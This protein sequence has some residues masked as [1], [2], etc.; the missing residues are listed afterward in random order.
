MR[1]LVLHSRYLS[2]PA[3]GENRVVDDEIRLLNEGGHDVTSWTP[4]LDDDHGWRRAKAGVDVVWSLPAARTVRDLMRRHRPDIVHCHNVFPA[5][6][7]AVLRVAARDARVVVTLHNYR[8][9]C[10]PATFLRDNRTCEDCLHR[11]VAWPGVVHRCYRNSLAA[12]SAVALSCGLHRKMGT[13]NRVHR[14][15]AV[16]E[17][18]RHKHEQAGFGGGRMDVKPNFAWPAERRSGPGDYFL[19]MGRLSNE[20]GL[21][22]LVGDWRPGLRPLLIVGDGPEMHRLRRIANGGVRFVG[23]VPAAE[24]PAIVAR[25]RALVVPSRC[26]EGAPRSVVEAYAAGVPVVASDIGALPELVADGRT[27]R[28]LP[29]ADRDGWMSALLHLSEDDRTSARLGA[30]AFDEWQRR[31]APPESLRALERIYA[32]A[33]GDAA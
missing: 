9:L 30:G 31:F 10:L 26:Y 20:K 25:A 15:I 22:L 3:S 32:A 18:V 16:S 8:W 13:M 21:D 11:S 24:V 12:S 14:Y 1:V 29:H 7:P 4:S 33:L 6:S 17:F 27:G 28:L 5:L 19:Y 2:G 23:Q